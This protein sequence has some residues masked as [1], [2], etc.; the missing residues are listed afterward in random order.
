MINNEVLEQKKYIEKVSSIL[1]NRYNGKD[2]P[3]AY[4]HSY[5]CQQNLSDGEKV[6]GMLALMG[7]GFTDSP[8]LAEFVLYN[9]CAIRENAED[10]VFG[11]V[12]ALKHHKK[13]KPSMII[14]L[15][16]CM[17]QQQHIVE[18]IK[19]SYSHVDILF[20]THVLHKLPETVYNYLISEKRVFDISQSDEFVMEGV[21]LKRDGDIKAW[22][23]IMYGCNKFCTYCI[24]P[25]VRGR[26]RSR[27]IASVVDE[28]SEVVSS[29]YREVTLLGQNVNSYG[30]G[31]EGDI[32]FSELLK[33]VNDIKGDFRIRFMSPHP[34][35]ATNEMFDTISDCEKVCNHVHMPVQ[36]GSDKILKLMNRSYSVEEYMNLIDYGKSKIKDISFT[37]D[38]IVGFP[39]ETYED[40]LKTLDLIK[41]A[42]FSSLF[43]F[44]YSKRVG[45]RAAKMDDPISD[46]DKSK[47]FRELLQVQQEIGE[48]CY[49]KLVGT[50]QRVLVDGIGKTDEGYV[51]GRTE[52]NV[53]VDLKGSKDLIGNFVDVKITEPL[54]WAVLGELK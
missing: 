7:Y 29:G 44:I 30:L 20:G 25:Y 31:L 1:L 40:F 12:G 42:E 51:T 2:V 27:D 45:T 50:E 26:E 5:G 6:K 47:W 15:C 37:S 32:N 17:M 33:R 52:G 36:S 23:P 38:V 16:G 39:G 13:R 3:L 41:Y 11:N 19:S 28:I 48:K 35:D 54:R 46:S 21:P 49:K 22:I 8:D 4:V 9:T 14:A 24:V 43:N 10:R 53:I 34:K 18:K